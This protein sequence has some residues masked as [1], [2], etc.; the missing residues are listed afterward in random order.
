MYP[1]NSGPNASTCAAIVA[2]G[3]QGYRVAA[4]CHVGA[5]GGIPCAEASTVWQQFNGSAIN[6]E[7]NAVTSHLQRGVQEMADLITWFNQDA[8]V[9]SR[10]RART[11]SFCMMRSGQRRDDWDQGL[12]FFLPNM[13][14][15][16]PPGVV[17]AMLK[18]TWEPNALAVALSGGGGEISAA[19][20]IA[21]D[22]S[23]VVVELANT[24]WGSAPGTASLSLSGFAP[25]AAVD[26][27]LMAEPGSGA[28]N[29]TAGNTPAN[30]TY[31]QAVHST[32][33]W[34]A[35]GVLNITL[36]PLS[37]AVVVL[38]SA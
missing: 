15:L 37:A 14:W 11:A 33:A 34:P 36:P 28:V 29:S 23:R 8:G 12:S 18:D 31:I 3:V 4:D 21:G 35:S 10:L 20:Q 6:C 16:Q 22:R 1:E 30:P 17:H 32:L 2:A 5:S 24:L 26:L 9:A 27:Y 38:H 13:T 25:A 19:A 7:T